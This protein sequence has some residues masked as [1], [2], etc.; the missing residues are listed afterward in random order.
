MSDKKSIV[1]NI[2]WKT[3]LLDSLVEKIQKY[4]ELIKKFSV[5]KKFCLVIKTF[6]YAL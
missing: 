2:H 1:K 3:I 4:L 6:Y 5:E